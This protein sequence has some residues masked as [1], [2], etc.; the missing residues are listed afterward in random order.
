MSDELIFW[1]RVLSGPLVGALIGWLTN[2]LAVK[3]LFHPYK[4]WHIGKIRLPLTPGIIPR[5]RHELAKAIG[6]AVEEKLLTY[7]DLA[8]ALGATADGTRAGTDGASLSFGARRLRDLTGNDADRNAVLD[9]C[10][11]RICDRLRAALDDPAVQGMIEDKLVDAVLSSTSGTMLGMFLNENAVRSLVAGRIDSAVLRAPSPLDED[12]LYEYVRGE[13]E[14]LSER[15]LGSLWGAEEADGDTAALL[16]R[17]KQ[18]LMTAVVRELLKKLNVEALVTARIDA[19]PMK[20]LEDLVLSVMKKEL[21]A[22]VNLGALIGF[23]IG[24]IN[25]FI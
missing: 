9:L 24:V 17:V 10:A 2:A 20:D 23:A 25:I 16:A 3:M 6:R 18:D 19:M 7:D 13:L 8:A 5:R 4:P 14:K 11:E 22:I 21:R 15:E 12:P 1:L